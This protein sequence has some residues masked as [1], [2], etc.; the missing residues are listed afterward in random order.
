M[1]VHEPTLNIPA[2][3]KTIFAHRGLPTRA[4]ENTLA[5]FQATVQ[6]GGK[7]IE[8]DVDIIADGTPI[9]IHDSTLDRTTDHKGSFYPLQQADLTSIDAGRWFGEA[10]AGERIPT[11]RQLIDFINEHQLNLNLE[12]KQNEQGARQTIRLINAIIKELGRLSP[13][14]QVI[15]SSFSQPILMAFHER[16]PAYAIGVLFE[17]A[18]LQSDW[19]TVLELCGATYAHVENDGLTHQTVEQLSTAGYGVN[20][21]TV[22]NIERAKELFAWGCTGVFTDISDKMTAVLES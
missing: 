19:L 15:V 12:I 3:N 2:L 18:T 13:Q 5:A 14:C 1:P 17:T 22:N 21:W 16:A 11:L 6:G 9:I 8:T 7:W 4:P 20:V 10:F